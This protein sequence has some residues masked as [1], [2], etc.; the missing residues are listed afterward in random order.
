M[1]QVLEISTKVGTEPEWEEYQMLLNYCYFIS[2]QPG[3]FDLH[4]SI[5]RIEIRHLGCKNF[6]IVLW[7]EKEEK[8]LKNMTVFEI[9]RGTESVYERLISKEKCYVL[10]ELNSGKIDLKRL[11]NRAV[12]VLKSVSGAT[13]DTRIWPEEN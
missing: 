1:D 5:E 3:H 13:Y 11:I 4:S 10:R 9:S 7:T 8:E 12:I 2:A 6:E